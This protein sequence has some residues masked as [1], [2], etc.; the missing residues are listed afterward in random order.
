MAF[1][2]SSNDD[3][4]EEKL[5]EKRYI[6]NAINDEFTHNNK[7][8]KYEQVGIT[9]FPDKSWDW[10]PFYW[11]DNMTETIVMKEDVW[12]YRAVLLLALQIDGDD[13]E[14]TCRSIM[15]SDD[16]RYIVERLEPSRIAKWNVGNQKQYQTNGFLKLSKYYYGRISQW[17]R[18]YIFGR[19]NVTGKDLLGIDIVVLNKMICNVTGKLFF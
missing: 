13:D 14:Y 10:H 1:F 17:Q 7:E 9:R 5:S 18:C 11:T 16:V 19:D 6:W 8:P 15:K 3:L 2:A 12:S 4:N